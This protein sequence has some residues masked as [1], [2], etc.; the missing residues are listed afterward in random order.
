MSLS[1]RASADKPPTRTRHGEAYIAVDAPGKKNKTFQSYEEAL[2]TADA[3][4]WQG[5]LAGEVVLHWKTRTRKLLG[6]SKTETQLELDGF[7]IRRKTG[8]ETSS[9]NRSRLFAQGL[10]QI[11]GV[12][13]TSVFLPVVEI[14]H[15]ALS[16]CDFCDL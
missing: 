4:K 6:I 13:F 5:G 12:D 14:Y 9:K 11:P 1:E 10:P 3:G 7:L 16:V 15:C 8:R 2:K